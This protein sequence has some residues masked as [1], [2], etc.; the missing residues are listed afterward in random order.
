MITRADTAALKGGRGMTF[1]KAGLLTTGFVAAFAVGVMTG[2]TIRDNWSRM[3]APEEAA[4]AQPAEKSASAPVKNDRPATRAR[5]SS[6][7][8]PEAIAPKKAYNTIQEIAVNLWEPELR[9]RVKAVLNPGSRLDVAAAD[10]DSSEQFMTVAHAARNTKVPFM[11]LKDRVL[12]R[13][14]SLAEAIHEF[15]PELDAKAEVTRARA[16]AR[17][18]L[19]IAG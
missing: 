19:E 15:K 14:Q 11:V 8:A 9:D 18:D 3:N 10:F 16:A 17:S 13:G 6:S 7:R 4:A 1:R 2:P 12:N 5:T